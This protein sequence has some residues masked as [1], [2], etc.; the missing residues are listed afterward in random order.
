MKIL[1]EPNNGP[2]NLTMDKSTAAASYT[3]SIGT[4]VGGLLSL[5]NIALALGILFTVITF[6]MNWRYQSK[7]HELE[8]QKRREDAEYH[9]ARMRELVRDDEQALAECKAGYGEQ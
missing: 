5:N 4:G 9:K 7:K 6:L 3:A 2:V 1:N 8:L